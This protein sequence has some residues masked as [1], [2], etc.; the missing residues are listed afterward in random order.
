MF[1]VN[2]VITNV[3]ELLKLR[4]QLIFVLF[5]YTHSRIYLQHMKNR[6]LRVI[7]LLA[8]IS[9]IGIFIIQSFWF[10]KA[11]D[12][13]EKQFNLNVTVALQNTAEALLTYQHLSI[14]LECM[15]YQV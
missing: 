10:K 8:V 11:F 9:I 5:L 14:P 6:N 4:L 1:T 13:K 2:E 15:V 12:L 7:I 3:I